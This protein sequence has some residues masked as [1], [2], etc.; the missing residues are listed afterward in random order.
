MV[1]RSLSTLVQ[2]C[3]MSQL[4]QRHGRVSDFGPGGLGSIIIRGIGYKHFFTSYI[5]PSPAGPACCC[6]LKYQV[7]APNRYC[8]L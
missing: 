6:P 7:R 3:C 8:I 5:L 2:P 4:L 1:G